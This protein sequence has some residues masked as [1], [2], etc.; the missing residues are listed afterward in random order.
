MATRTIVYSMGQLT[1][2]ETF[3][4]PTRHYNAHN[5]TSYHHSSRGITTRSWPWLLQSFIKNIITNRARRRVGIMSEGDKYEV[6]ERIG[7]FFDGAS[8]T[9]KLSAYRTWFLWSY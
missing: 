7:E 5:A 9:Q 8:S 6:L 2:T 3:K 1:I 4:N